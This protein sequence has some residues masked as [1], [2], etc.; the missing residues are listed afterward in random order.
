MKKDLIIKEKNE[1]LDSVYK[2]LE[3]RTVDVMKNAVETMYLATQNTKYVM[4]QQLSIVQEALAGH[5]QHDGYFT[6]WYTALGLKS[7]NVYACIRYYKMLFAN[8]DNQILEEISF[9]K[10]SEVAKLNNNT[11]LQKE[12]IELA[13][14]KDMKVKQVEELIKEVKEKKEV[15]KELI[16]GIYNETNDSGAK[17]KKFIKVTTSFIEGLK[18]QSEEVSKENVRKVLKLVSEVQELCSIETVENEDSEV[19]EIA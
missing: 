11:E 7:D 4:G 9:S 2:E 14:L 1:K 16:D 13:P 8:P 10:G 6:R 17:L 15:T 18:E 3:E 12:V 5:N 19:K